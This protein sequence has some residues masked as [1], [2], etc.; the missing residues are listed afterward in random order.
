[1]SSG[2]GVRIELRRDHSTLLTGDPD[3]DRS[4]DEDDGE[5]DTHKNK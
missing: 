2:L 1:M 3:D 4:D 5:E